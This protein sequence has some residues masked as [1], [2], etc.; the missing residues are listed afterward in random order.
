VRR[1]RPRP[2]EEGLAAAHFALGQHLHRTGHP[3]DA[4][5]HFRAATRL[6]PENW[7]YKRQAWDLAG[8]AEAARELYG[9]DWL[10]DVRALGAENY[11]PPLELE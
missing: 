8:S 2:V 1:S 5:P 6:Q 3:G 9:S 11:Y 7:T 10:A 4:V